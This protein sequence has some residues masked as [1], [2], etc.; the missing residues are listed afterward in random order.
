MSQ[1]GG[2]VQVLNTTA[3]RGN[4]PAL[5][6]EPD[7]AIKSRKAGKR[8]RAAAKTPAIQLRPKTR[9]KRELPCAEQRWPQCRYRQR[10]RPRG[11]TYQIR[12]RHP[13]ER[14][15]DPKTWRTETPVV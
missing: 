14:Y 1:L 9:R 7:P 5:Q 10:T 2:E 4:L 12:T 6:A 13:G 11:R 8:D 3:D 15:G